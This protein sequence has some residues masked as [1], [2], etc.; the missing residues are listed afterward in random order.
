MNL[1]KNL[2]RQLTSNLTLCFS[3]IWVDKISFSKNS[4]FQLLGYK[5]IHQTRKNCKGGEVCVFVNE[6]LSFKLIEDLNINCEAIQ[7]LSIEISSS[8]SK[9]ILNTIYKPPNGDNGSF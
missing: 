8:K 9:I 7:S 5:V 4:N 1:S 3:E 6:S 2:I